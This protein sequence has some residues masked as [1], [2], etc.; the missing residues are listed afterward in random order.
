MIAVVVKGGGRVGER[1]GEIVSVRTGRKVDRTEGRGSEERGTEG[2][3]RRE[4]ANWRKG[5][6]DEIKKNKMKGS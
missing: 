2:K 3:E 6:K 1:I 5:Q 4:E